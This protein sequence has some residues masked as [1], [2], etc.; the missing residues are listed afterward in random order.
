[1][2][3]RTIRPRDNWR[4]KLEQ[5]GFTFHSTDGIY[6]NEAACYQFSESEIDSIE[7]ATAELHGMCLKAVSHIVKEK[8][9]DCLGIPSPFIPLIERSWDA[10]EASLYGRF[11]FAYDGKDGLKLLEYNADTPTSLVEA[12][13]AQWAWLEDVHPD[14]DQF[15]SIHEKLVSRF[16]ELG[17]AIPGDAIFFFACIDDSPEDFVNVQYLRDTADQA[18]LTSRQVFMEDIG[19]SA[20]A[21]RFYDPEQMEIQYLTRSTQR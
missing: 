1:M 18:G 19:Y 3:R 20:E 6:W 8:R 21:K 15:N 11:D 7:A 12:S 5:I 4:D 2:K 9:Y 16:A 13:V 14:C 17:A 10:G